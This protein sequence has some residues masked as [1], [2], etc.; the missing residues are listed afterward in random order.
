MK[1]DSS[2]VK[3][4]A[5]EAAA[6]MKAF[7]DETASAERGVIKLGGAVKTAAQAAAA[8]LGVYKG[9]SLISDFIRQ[10]VAYNQQLENAQLGI[11]A[12][13]AS[14]MDV[15]DAQGKMLE[16]AEK[17]AA[18]Q[19]VSVRMA[20][21]LD[22]ASIQSPAEYT[23]LLA[24]FQTVLAPATQMKIAWKDTLDMVV[25]MSNVLSSLNVPMDRLAI[26]MQM[27]LTGRN[28]SRSA[29][30]PKLGLTAAELKS[31]ADGERYV[32]NFNKRLEQ[33]SEAGKAVENTLTAITAYYK[34]VIAAYSAETGQGFF[35]SLKNAMNEVS[36]TL[37][38]INE[39][40][41]LFEISEE[42]KD[43]TGLVISLQN[44]LGRGLESAASAFTGALKVTSSF[45]GEYREEIDEI[46][47]AI[48]MVVAALA[49][50]Q[51]GLLV[52]N[53]TLRESVSSMLTWITTSKG[54]T[55]SALASA[56]ADHVM[57]LAEREA[58]LAAKQRILT[59]IQEATSDEALAVAKAELVTA[60]AGLAAANTRTAQTQT[61]LAIAQR[62][63]AVGAMTLGKAM[64]GVLAAVGG[65]VGA[66]L[67][68][69]SAGVAYFSMR[70]TEGERINRDYGASLEAIKKGGEEAKTAFEDA[71][72]AV[73]KMS[74]NTLELEKLKTEVSL[75]KLSAEIDAF[76]VSV[77]DVDT[78]LA[79]I[80]GYIGAGGEAQIRE[81]ARLGQEFNNLIGKFKEGKVGYEEFMDQ[82]EGYAVSTRNTQIADEISK[83]ASA[84]AWQLKWKEAIDKT[85]AAFKTGKDAAEE[86]GV[87][88]QNVIKSMDPKE[89]IK[90][91]HNLE[92]L[93]L[94][95]TLTAKE[96]TEYKLA[97][98]LREAAA[99]M[100]AYAKSAGSGDERG[101]GAARAR[102]L[103]GQFEII[104]AG[105]KA[106]GMTL[107]DYAKERGSLSDELLKVELGETAYTKLKQQ[108]RVEALIA[109]LTAE[110]GIIE[111][112]ILLNSNMLAFSENLTAQEIKLTKMLLA[113]DEV[114]LASYNKLIGD[115]RENA[116]RLFSG[117][118]KGSA[119]SAK[120]WIDD[121]NYKIE[122]LQNS[123][124]SFDMKIKKELDG[125]A[126]S[127]KSAG[128]SFSTAKQKIEEYE[129]AL[130]EDNQRKY[131]DAVRDLDLEIAKLSGDVDTV[132][133][134]EYE[135]A[136]EDLTKRFSQ[137]GEITDEV[138]KKIEKVAK[139]Q[140][141]QSEKRD[142][143][144]VYNFYKDLFELSGDYGRSL[145][146]TN[147]LLDQQAELLREMNIPEKD[148]QQWKNLKLLEESRDAVDGLRRG[149][150]KYKEE[151][152][153]YAKQV[154]D[155]TINSFQSMEDALVE[156]VRTGE[157]DFSDMVD[158]MIADL[159]RLSIRMAMF[160]DGSSG[161]GLLGGLIGVVGGVV[162]SLFGGGGGGSWDAASS[163]FSGMSFGLNAKGNTFPSDTGLEAWRNS[164]VD[165]PTFF[166]FARGIG[167]MGE[168]PGSPGEAIV[169]LSRM[170]GGDLGVKAQ[171][172][173]PPVQV[174]VNVVNN[175]DAQVRTEE[176][177]DANGNL[178]LN[179]IIEQVEQAVST[180]I[181]KG[182]SQIAAALDKTR[183][184]S[185]AGQLYRM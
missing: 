31:W 134:I 64:S 41:G 180:N 130:R 113:A 164:V 45:I 15:V 52:F 122:S 14:T 34:D 60:N 58:A 136:I 46:G 119:E 117:I 175:T 55:A 3:S 61:A 73:A 2:G 59:N 5:R 106:A 7:T 171:V 116:G 114:A 92:D 83:T 98:E 150:R 183:G 156:F 37:Y 127:A 35:E 10:G 112:R 78:I 101:E 42:V 138:R 76:K 124:E 139:E 53:P 144:A 1:F 115:V 107:K 158:S 62:N 39:Q 19:Q 4:G 167:L 160:G 48:P 118:G 184:L 90:H 166:A 75:R 24:A 145:E 49:G 155:I 96:F 69:L 133:L 157:L 40:T 151:A 153:N 99:A 44:A 131:I 100:D 111:A 57:A 104:S 135:K 77:D 70:E 120:S 79:E 148:I 94:Q 108:E 12:I 152:T 126:K 74:K 23:D 181:Y 163:S 103:K 89:A 123:G 51:V 132:R 82:V 165:K 27:M 21:A 93:F 162:G 174:F 179:V 9:F 140:Q 25:T 154:E 86:F 71:A 8:T 32:E 43:L 102:A 18:A 22:V 16:G 6:A 178:N 109:G 33:M 129:S 146:Y 20:K 88:G 142:Q 26:E 95:M 81:S 176:S 91:I 50:W 161:S 185:S 13:V 47:R 149:W 54:K 56:E 97:Q 11:A 68:A 67:L 38:F 28:L 159:I 65:P 110:K 121:L 143:S 87:S 80:G 169:P 105:A 128:V 170:S 147:H 85:I 137:F 172:S 17:F 141:K 84:I 66:A 30:A 168:K 177:Q 72:E 29:V 182:R 63:A 125:L 173:A 36:G